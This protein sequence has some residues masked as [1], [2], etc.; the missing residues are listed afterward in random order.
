M[1]CSSCL[2]TCAG[3][4]E[5]EPES[6]GGTGQRLAPQELG[7]WRDGARPGMR[8]EDWQALL[9][10]RVLLR[11]TARGQLG[12]GAF[13]QPVSKHFPSLNLPTDALKLFLVPA[14]SCS[15]GSWHSGAIQGWCLRTCLHVAPAPGLRVRGGTPACPRNKCFPG[16]N[17]HPRC[18]WRLS[19]IPS[20]RLEAGGCPGSSSGAGAEAPW[21]ARAAGCAWGRHD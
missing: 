13:T 11:C 10:P 21:G 4:R 14:A 16:P 7:G 3:E 17:V 12:G 2:C 19:A 20:S 6:A 8:D 18:H 1:L 15:A 9:P 5:G